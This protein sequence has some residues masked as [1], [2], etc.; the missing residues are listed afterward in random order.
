MAG[1]KIALSS[2]SGE[3]KTDGNDNAR[4]NL[5][6]TEA[7]AGFAILGSELH[8]GAVG[9]S[10]LVRP[11]E[12]TMNEHLEVSQ[13]VPLWDDYFQGANHNLSKYSITTT[14]MT[15]AQ[16]G[17]KLTLNNSGITTT[18]TG[19][20]VR[21]YR[22]FPLSQNGMTIFDG[23]V[24]FSLAIQSQNI[25]RFGLGVP[26]TAT[27]APVDGVYLEIDTSGAIKLVANYNGTT[28]T[29]TA[30]GFSVTAGRQYRVRILLTIDRAELWVDEALYASI[31][32]SS[33]NTNGSL[34]A[35]ASAYMFM[36]L[37]N[38]AA[39]AG[40]QKANVSRWSVYV[41]DVSGYRDNKIAGAGRGD[42][43]ISLVDGLAAAGSNSW[44]N[45][46]APAS[47][48]LSN[49]TSTNGVNV[50]GGQFQFAAVAGAETDYII[51]GF[52]VPAPSV[53]QPGK[54]LML[55]GVN[56][57][58]FNMGAAVATTPTLFQLGLGIGSTAVSLA[59]TDS[60]T[61]GTRAP[62]RIA[63]GGASAPVGAAVGALIDKFN[64]TF[65]APIMVEAGTFLHFILKMP[66]GTATA[67]QILRGTFTPYGY[68]E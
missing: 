18:T 63:I 31:D 55:T 4:V 17:G 68:F 54:N 44:A 5:P 27:T 49:T 8:N 9:S 67:S 12:A 36:Q 7:D 20:I 64:V 41:S 35:C 37:I 32:R 53:T 43:V 13:Y 30:T 10:R 61:A 1:A 62:R 42:S 26:N 22:T 52:Q 57:L 29:S 21:T 51:F 60:A 24:D 15:T 48:T 66:V 38:N 25:F 45:S 47:L 2:T 58:L 19:A 34:T 23:A 39:T 33:S 3:L 46:A 65:D 56:V 14:T 40:A 28:I 16:T 50:A 11:I 59:T 6:L